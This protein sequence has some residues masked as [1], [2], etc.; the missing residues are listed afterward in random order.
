MSSAEERAADPSSVPL[1]LSTE[2]LQ[3][4]TDRGKKSHIRMNVLVLCLPTSLADSTSLACPPGYQLK[5]NSLLPGCGKRFPGNPVSIA[6][7]KHNGSADLLSMV[8][9]PIPTQCTRASH[10]P[11]HSIITVLNIPKNLCPISHVC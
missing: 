11:A 7:P 10:S 1:S 4:V 6:L 5:S 3:E 8:C 9:L 2:V